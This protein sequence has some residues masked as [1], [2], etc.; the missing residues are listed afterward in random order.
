MS[1]PQVHLMGF[2]SCLPRSRSSY[3]TAWLGGRGENGGENEIKTFQASNEI[4]VNSTDVSHQYRSIP[5][6]ICST[7]GIH[8]VSV[9]FFALSFLCQLSDILMIIKEDP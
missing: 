7:L 9:Y 1:R 4:M 8:P 5:L 3:L 2:P 6:I